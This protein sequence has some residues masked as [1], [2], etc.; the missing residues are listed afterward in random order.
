MSSATMIKAKIAKNDEFYTPF[1]YIDSELPRHDA[2]LAGKS[3]LCP[4]DHPLYSE[5]CHWF[6]VNFNRLHLKCLVA[7]GRMLGES[8]E[9]VIRE[10]P[11]GCQTVSEACDASNRN[12]IRSISKCSYD[13]E[14]CADLIDRG[15]VV[16]TNP[17]FSTERTWL[18]FLYSHG[19]E[20]LLVASVMIISYKDVWK[21]AKPGW[22]RE[23]YKKTKTA[24]VFTRPDG[25]TAKLGLVTWIGTDH[26]M[27]VP[28]ALE[29]HKRV[30]ND[31]IWVKSPTTGVYCRSYRDIP[32]DYAGDIYV[33]VTSLA[34]LNTDQFEII[35]TD[36]EHYSNGTF[37]ANGKKSF[38][39]FIIR[40][41]HPAKR[42]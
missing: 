31:T 22:I 17:P 5:F 36:N 37:L 2:L 1:S 28:P 16:V 33:P 42:G 8:M 10:V 13:D 38:R 19:A 32:C 34:K 23:I 7:R 18:S 39:R 14:R 12:T 4:C 26:A 20:C 3:I 30:D 21:L 40:V 25:S 24:A 11:D 6:I 41:R 15:F 35:G 27:F 9:A 29:L